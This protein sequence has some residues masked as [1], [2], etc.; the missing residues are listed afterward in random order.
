MA[1]GA[2]FPIRDPARLVFLDETT[3]ATN[4]TRHHGRAPVGVRLVDDVPFGHFKGTRD[5]DVRDASGS[6][7]SWPPTVWRATLLIRS[8]FVPRLVV[9]LPSVPKVESRA[10]AV[11]RARS[12]RP[13]TRRVAWRDRPGRELWVAGPKWARRSSEERDI[14]RVPLRG[15]GAATASLTRG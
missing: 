13:S 10:P 7:L 8:L 9:T 11:S 4:M 5:K 1:K 14:V 2:A 15:L 12:S 6:A 3:A